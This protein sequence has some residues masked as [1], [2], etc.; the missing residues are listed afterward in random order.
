MK[1]GLSHTR[2]YQC[3]RNMLRRCYDPTYK[4]YHR[5]GGR[6]IKVC[7]R[8]KTNLHNFIEDMGPMP[9]G[10]TID[11]INNDKGYSHSNCRWATRKQQAETNTGL[12]KKGQ[13]LSSKTEFKIGNVPYFKTHE[14][15]LE[16]RKRMSNSAKERGYCGRKVGW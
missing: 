12:V 7:S 3:W 16:T 1:T 5:Y 2:E 6:G 14:V 13:R 11:R 15:S 9:V 10:H 8:W 4:F